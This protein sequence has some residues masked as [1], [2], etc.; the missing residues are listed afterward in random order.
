V[1]T[2]NVQNEITG[3]DLLDPSEIVSPGPNFRY[4]QLDA[5]DLGDLADRSFDVAI[6]IGLLEHLRPRAR[7]IAAIREAQ[8]VAARYC[9]VVPHRYAFIEPHFRMPL[10]SIWPDGLK[11]FA[12][13]R[14][15]LGTQRR[16]SEGRWQRINWLGKGEWREL[17]AD[18]SLR[19][20]NYWYGPCLQYY[21]ISGVGRIP[22]GRPSSST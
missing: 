11:S 2:F 20:D 12:I 18:P 6:G 7:L 10:F 19:I 16:D 8:R 21:V 3:I 1:A 5:T 22:E 15:R 17:F 4:R 14:W 9:F 13:R